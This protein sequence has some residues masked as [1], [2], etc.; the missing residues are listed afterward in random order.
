MNNLEISFENEIF[1]Y[2]LYCEIVDFFG[3]IL[4]FEILC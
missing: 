4:R 2:V 1:N 3:D